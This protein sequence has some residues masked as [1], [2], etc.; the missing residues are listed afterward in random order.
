[1]EIHFCCTAICLLA[2]DLISS[3]H[4]RPSAGDGQSVNGDVYK[5]MHGVKIVAR[6]I[7]LTRYQNTGTW[8]HL[9]T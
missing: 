6:G 4:L 3:E 5:I 9:K 2:E 7:L 1:M 8:E